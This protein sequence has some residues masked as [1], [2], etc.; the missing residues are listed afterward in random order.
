MPSKRENPGAE[1][2]ARGAEDKRTIGKRKKPTTPCTESKVG[3]NGSVHE[4]AGVLIAALAYAT[5]GWHVFPVPLN[6]KKSCK[7]KKHKDDPNW[8]MTKDAAEIQNDWRRWPNS[9]VGIP[10]GKINGFFVLEIDTK[11]GHGVDGAASLH[12]L[13]VR[14]GALPSTKQAQSPSGSLH[15][16]F[17]HPGDIKIK[18]SS[19]ELGP[20][21]DVR[22]DGGMVVAP[23][24]RRKDGEYIWN[25]EFAI[26]EAPVWLIEDFQPI[27]P[28]NANGKDEKRPDWLIAKKHNN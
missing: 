19:S 11:A 6:T 17:K 13:E 21:I 10:T 18:N 23:P 22:G 15:Y 24:T 14:H 12:A 8:G 20:G 5:Q 2:A 16:Y 25:N 3:A 7:K 4:P 9:G 27:D 26:A 28:Y 1:E